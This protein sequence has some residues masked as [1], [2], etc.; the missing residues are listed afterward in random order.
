MAEFRDLGDLTEYAHAQIERIARMQRDLAEHAG[1]GH[2]PRG[3]VTARTGP[4]GALQD[5]RIEPD[6]RRLPVDELTAELHAAISAAQHDFAR[7]A[8]EIMAPILD[9]RPSEQA[10]AALEAG[11]SRLDALAADLEHLARRSHLD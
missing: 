7:R 9:T 2:S 11:M 5:L 1:E 8:D 6:A 10:A 4:G 3:Y